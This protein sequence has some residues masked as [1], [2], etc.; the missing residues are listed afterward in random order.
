MHVEKISLTSND[1]GFLD[2]V[3]MFILESEYMALFYRRAARERRPSP[4]SVQRRHMTNLKS[5]RSVHTFE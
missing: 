2:P 4:S 3:P 5:G 1:T